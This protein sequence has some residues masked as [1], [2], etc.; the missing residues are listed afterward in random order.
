MVDGGPLIWGGWPGDRA[1]SDGRREVFAPALLP[2]LEFRDAEA[3]ATLD[4]GYRFGTALLNHRKRDVGELAGWLHASP[5]GRLA[6]LDDVSLVFVPEAGG[7][8]R[9]PGGGGGWWGAPPPSAP[10]GGV[11]AAPAR[12]HPRPP[13]R[14]LRDLGRP[15]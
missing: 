14:L 5:E 9:W 12:A 7:G 10:R 4:A 13:P 15:D 11:L 8:G 3:F 6:Y 2:R 1:M